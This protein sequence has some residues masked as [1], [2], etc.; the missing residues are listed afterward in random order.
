[1]SMIRRALP[2][3]IRKGFIGCAFLMLIAFGTVGCASK[4]S[5]PQTP[6]NFFGTPSPEASRNN[7]AD[8]AARQKRI[9]EESTPLKK[10]PEMTDQASEKLADDLVL[11]GHLVE[12]FMQYEN[13]L[14]KHPGN[15]RLLYKR[16]LVYLVKN[17]N[18]K[19]LADFREALKKDPG[20]AL[21]HQGAGQALYKMNH[22]NEAQKEFEL[23]LKADG[24]L[25]ISHDFLGIIYDDQKRSDLSAA[26]YKAAIALKPDW[27]EAYNN[28]GVSYCLRGDYKNAVAAFDEAI[29][30][31]FSSRKVGNN[32]GLA[33]CHLGKDREALQ[34]FQRSGDEAQAYNNLG[35][36]YL[37]EGNYREAANDFERAI[38]LRPGF[39]AQASE[40]LKKAEAA[41]ASPTVSRSPPS[42]EA[43]IEGLTVPT[44][45][46]I[47][48]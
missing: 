4:N 23:A 19:A 41:L 34:A 33:L 36:Y 31:G 45:L 28:L 32:L 18:A 2:A 35:V 38:R 40:N 43:P 20:N 27:G 13:L 5:H 1:M 8:L 16:G 15:S 29:D 39:Y 12:A 22:L 42:G 30:K 14:R 48:P 21:I 3:Q 37:M 7:N 11:H 26:Q 25:W 47:E 44:G 6:N 46:R 24:K 10:L 9:A 17:H